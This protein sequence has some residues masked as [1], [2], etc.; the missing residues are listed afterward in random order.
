MQNI[1]LLTAILLLENSDKQSESIASLFSVI[2][3][4]RDK[5][6]TVSSL[7]ECLLYLQHYVV[8][9]IL[10]HLK[11][12]N[13]EQ[14][15]LL[16]EIGNITSNI[17]IILLMMSQ[18]KQ[19]LTINQSIDRDHIAKNQLSVNTLGNS[20]N[21]A[22]AKITIADRLQYTQ[23]ANIKLKSQLKYTQELFETVVNTTSTLMWM[24]DAEENYTFLN[25]AWL[26]FTGL[27]ST[28]GLQE[29][30]R[31]RIHKQDLEHCDRAYQSALKKCRGFQI[32]YRLKRF[33]NN[34]RTILNT[35]V[36]RYSPQGDFAGLLC[37]CLD[38]TQRKKAEEKVIQQAKID[39]I[40]TDIT[41]NIHSSLE[42]NIIL[43][44]A[45]ERISEYLWL[46]KIS[47]VKIINCDCFWQSTSNT[48]FARQGTVD[49][50][51]L[52]FESGHTSLHSSCNISQ[53]QSEVSQK[54][55]DN[56]EQFAKGKIITLDNHSITEL[57][58]SDSDCI[59]ASYP[60]L[61]VPIISS[62]KLWGLICVEQN[63]PARCW[64][65]SEIRLLEKA[66]IQL[67]IAIK[68]SE[69]YQELEE[70]A[71]IDDLTQIANRRRFD[72]YLT[73]EW[74]RLA[75]EKQALSLIMCD[76]DHFKL[77]NDTYGHQAGDRCLQRV[78]QALSKVTKRPADL[79]ARYGGEEFVIV[80]PNTNIQGAKYIAQQIRLQI[81]SLKIPHINSSVDLYITLSFGVATCI[82]DGKI[83]VHT[84]VS[85]AD[86]GL[87]QA[88]ELGRNRIVEFKIE[89]I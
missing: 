15:N 10:L 5:F 21:A 77:Y 88:K 85:A 16:Q 44:T 75:R 56:Y 9:L 26:S 59:N 40:L 54:I 43:Q 19:T 70:L 82:P 89:D 81:E 78:A 51:V 2:T 69:L 58:A 48:V 79:V 46:D 14:S 1:S 74:R 23:Q 24:I 34:Y 35:A 67:G 17:P 64:Q 45:A 63:L 53:Y 76:V 66:A 13:I 4:N 87:Y 31:D 25:Q 84:L 50:L 62:Q 20:I 11:F 22:L 72:R 6:Y 32:E 39:R 61:L 36:R 30:W 7:N 38:I 37:S 8:D 33:D 83:D 18:R 3:E 47:I 65:T 27:T 73:T 28:E 29:N 41:Q 60:L 55:I 80:L 42:L 52:L 12:S 68:Q 71:V 57:L 86:R 49:R